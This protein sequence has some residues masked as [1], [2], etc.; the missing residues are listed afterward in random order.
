MKQEL[1]NKAISLG[2]NVYQNSL[3]KWVIKGL[4]NKKIWILQEQQSNAW[5]MTFDEL[6]Q[7]SLGTEKTLEALDMLVRYQ[8]T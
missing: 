6:S 4:I 3:G 2:C 8:S 7:V 5:L 1:L